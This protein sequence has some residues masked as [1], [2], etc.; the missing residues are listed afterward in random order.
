MYLYERVNRFNPVTGQP[1]EEWLISSKTVC[2]YT[3]E[4]MES[5][6][7]TGPLVDLN[8]GYCHDV[9]PMWD[10]DDGRGWFE[11]RGLS[12]ESLMDLTYHFKPATQWGYAD[13]SMFLAREWL[14]G[15]GDPDSVFHECLYLDEALR[16]ARVRTVKRLLEDETLTHEALGILR[17]DEY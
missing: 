3:G 16:R 5:D 17:E 2:D 7:E 9:E 10:Q 11:G 14:D 1:T 13:V 6:L 15:M 12:Y 8:T 4:V